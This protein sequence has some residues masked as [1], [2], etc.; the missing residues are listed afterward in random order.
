MARSSREPTGSLVAGLL[1]ELPPI[2]AAELDGARA[3]VS[4][5]AI[6]YPLGSGQAEEVALAAGLRPMV[7]QL[8][9]ARSLASARARFERA[10]LR[11][12]VAERV[13]GPT[14]NG[15]DHTPEALSPGDPG[16]RQALFVGRDPGRIGEAIACD[17]AKTDEGDR[18]LGRLLGYPRCCVEAFV[19]TSRHR[20]N[21]ELFAAA[22]ERT[23]GAPRARLNALD[24]GVFHFIS[25]SPCRFDCAWSLTYADAVAARLVRRHAGF[26]ARVDEALAAH[27]LVLLDEVQLSLRG[28]FDGAGVAV[29]EVWPT[30]RDRH[31]SAALEPEAHEAVARLLGLARRA[32]RV[33]VDME[34][35]RLDGERIRGTQGALLVA[36]GGCV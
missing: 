21:T 26:V 17:L 28:A 2:D 30:A 10:G 19:G 25:W 18:E 11:T 13:Y 29:D 32:R 12:G 5:R 1:Q 27:R 9:D 34:G 4:E 6:V 35:L 36:F 20:L 16:A 15:W 8:L 7:R 24:L 3:V 31:P 23:Q 22:A 33:A 14:R